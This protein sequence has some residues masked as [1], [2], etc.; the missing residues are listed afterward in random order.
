M[1]ETTGSVDITQHQT[2]LPIEPSY[3]MKDTYGDFIYNA[4]L[5]AKDYNH[6]STDQASLE[7]LTGRELGVLGEIPAI[8]HA[9]TVTEP[10]LSLLKKA[11]LQLPSERYT[12]SNDNE[13]LQLLK[14]LEGAE[15]RII[16]QYPQ[17]SDEVSSKL[18]WID[19]EILAYLSDKRNIPALVPREHVAW[20]KLMSLKEILETMPKFPIVLKTGDGR[21]TSGGNGVKLIKEESQLYEI[22]ETFGDLN[23]IIVEEFIPEDKNI[24][25]H[26]LIDQHGEIT[27]L[28][29]SEQ[30]VDDDGCFMSSWLTVQIEEQLNDVVKT[31][32]QVTKKL[33]EKGYIGAAGYDV[34][35]KGNDFYFI[36]LNIRFNASTCGLL[37]YNSIKKKYGTTTVRLCNLDWEGSLSRALPLVDDYMTNGQFIPLSLLDADYLT[38]K[39]L[40]SKVVGLAIGHTIEEVEKTLA[41]MKQKGLVQK[42]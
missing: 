3:S 38:E 41:D 30:I 37:L 40:P 14:K 36:D 7:A 13:Y 6:F 15:K 11:G 22:D 23:Q 17:P 26:Y 34:L 42:E 19:P 29:K 16:F 31:G 32:F 28:G 10:A 1:K 8:C 18:Y 9:A 12:Y 20:R 24:S 39:N 35:I 25:V 2:S 21:P 5:Y 33:A 4:K 27:F